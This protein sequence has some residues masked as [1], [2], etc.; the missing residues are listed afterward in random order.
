MPGV[1]MRSHFAS[2]DEFSQSIYPVKHSWSDTRSYNLSLE[3]EALLADSVV[4]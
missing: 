4:T 2:I 3:W 1:Y